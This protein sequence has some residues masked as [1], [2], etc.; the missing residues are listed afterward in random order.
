MEHLHPSFKHVKKTLSLI[1]ISVMEGQTLTGVEEA[2]Q[3]LRK[4]GLVK[5][6]KH[7]G[8]EVND[9]GDITK[10]SLQAK[11][12]AEIADKSQNPKYNLHDIEVLGVVNQRLQELNY[13][14]SKAGRFVLNLGG[15][16]GI[17]SATITGL[18][19]AHPNLRLIWFDAHGDCNTPATSASGNYH[20]MPAAHAFGWFKEG[21]VKSFKWLDKGP[22][23]DTSRVVYIG[24]RDLDAP[25]KKL[26]QD[27]KVKFYTPFDIDDKGGIKNVMDEALQYLKADK[28]DSNPLHV[29][30]D[31]DGCDPAFIFGTGTKARGGVSERES[32]YIL[33]R[34]AATGNLVG[35][36]VVEI[37]P[38]LDIVKQREHFHGDDSDIKGSASICNSIELIRSALGYSSR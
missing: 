37:N 26:L 1:G 27:H 18:L 20:G 4:G 31:V 25:E 5:V 14:E 2:P 12:D 35:L 38:A 30:W 7:L 6:I 8:W 33:Q 23:L 19:K 17:A 15:D 36:D 29:T 10:E 32:H 11:I 21:D 3:L 28:N 9:L 24:L 22:F 16:H 34:V 13:Q